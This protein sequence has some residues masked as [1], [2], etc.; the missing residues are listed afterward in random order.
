MSCLALPVLS[1][2][3]LSGGRFGRERKPRGLGSAQFGDWHWQLTPLG[4]GLYEGVSGVATFLGYLAAAT[5]E[6]RLRGASASRTPGGATGAQSIPEVVN[7]IGGFGG[8]GGTIHTL[9]HPGA[10]WRD[11]EL[12]EEARV[13]VDCQPA[14]IERDEQLD[15]IG[16]AAGCIGILLSLRRHSPSP[17]LL[18]VASLG[19][20]L[21]LAIPRCETWPGARPGPF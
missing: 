7:S 11:G 10:M 8:L 19:G 13:A 9:A 4:W 18:A 6:K 20:P 16:G 17:S 5:G 14:R 21:A 2:T 15:L 3:S 1:G 12:L